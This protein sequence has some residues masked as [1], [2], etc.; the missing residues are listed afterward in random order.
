MNEVDCSGER[1]NDAEK[2]KDNG[3]V[4]AIEILVCIKH[5]R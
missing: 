4:G 1:G 3:I 2:I 5:F